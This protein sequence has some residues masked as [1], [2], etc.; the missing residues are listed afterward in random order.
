MYHYVVRAKGEGI[1]MKSVI[2]GSI[3]AI[4]IAVAAGAVLNSINPSAGQAF[5][6]DSVRLN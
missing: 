1:V 2:I 5:S 6:T 4:F 3:A